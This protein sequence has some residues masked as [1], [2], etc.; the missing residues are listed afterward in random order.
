MNKKTYLCFSGKLVNTF[1]EETAVRIHDQMKGI[2]AKVPLRL[3]G[4]VGWRVP[5]S[6]QQGYAGGLVHRALKAH[7]QAHR[8]QG[9]V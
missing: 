4:F 8:C 1:E 7:E 3:G 5:P 6:L 2:D 9:Q